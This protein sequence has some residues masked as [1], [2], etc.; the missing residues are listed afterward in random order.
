MLIEFLAYLISLSILS[1]LLAVGRVMWYERQIHKLLAERDGKLAALKRKG[2]RHSDFLAWQIERLCRRYTE[3]I[4]WLT[5][6]RS[7]LLAKLPFFEG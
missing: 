5:V 6:S 1:Y 2:I 7:M 4:A 3:R